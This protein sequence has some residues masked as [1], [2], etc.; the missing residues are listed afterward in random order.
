MQTQLLKV[1]VLEE[2]RVD[3]KVTRTTVER[4]HHI[5]CDVHANPPLGFDRGCTDVRRT[6]EVFHLQ[7]GVVGVNRF[8]FEH[9]ESGRGECTRFKGLENGVF[10]DNTSP[11]AIDNVAATPRT[12]LAN[13]RHGCETFGVHKVVGLVG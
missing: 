13:V 10:I 5:G 11:C 4:I 1:K 2:G 9:V 8:M 3:N 7:E 12:I 6:M